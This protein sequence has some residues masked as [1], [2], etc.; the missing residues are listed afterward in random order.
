MASESDLL[1]SRPPE[2]GWQARLAE[3]LGAGLDAPQRDALWTFAQSRDGGPAALLASFAHPRLGPALR[4]IHR[5]PA[6]ALLASRLARLSGLSRTLFFARFLDETGET[7]S[8]YVSRWRVHLAASF[9]RVQDERLDLLAVRV[10]LFD[11]SALTK[12]FRRNTGL[13]P[14]AY[15]RLHRRPVGRASAASVLPPGALSASP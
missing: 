5:E 12:A 13:N 4:V 11:G 3:V 14:G 8:S 7:P 9:L 15:R 6:S 2:P 1:S 10:G